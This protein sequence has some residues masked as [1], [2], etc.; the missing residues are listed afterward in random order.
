MRI[1]CNWPQ[2]PYPIYSIATTMLTKHLHNKFSQRPIHTYNIVQSRTNYRFSLVFY[3]SFPYTKCKNFSIIGNPLRSAK[4]RF[5]LK[6]WMWLDRINS[7]A[8]LVT[9]LWYFNVVCVCVLPILLL[10]FKPHGFG[11][12]ATVLGLQ[13]GFMCERI[14]VPFNPIL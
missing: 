1:K 13:N 3:T 4:F 6:H 11:C 2:S 8:K 5:R 12:L 9:I 14:C 7:D 10:L